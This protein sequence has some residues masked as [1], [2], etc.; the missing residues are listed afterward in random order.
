VLTSRFLARHA[1]RLIALALV[2]C[3]Y[4]LAG[5]PKIT[6]TERQTLASRFRFSRRALPEPTG[7]LKSVREVNPSLQQISGWISAVGAGVALNDLDGDGLSNDMC[8][9]DP[10]V[11]K[12]MVAP[13]P[14]TPQRYKMIVLDPWPLPYDSTTMA[15]MG[16]LPGDVNED[17]RMDLLVYY[18]GRAPVLFLR[19]DH[20]YTPTELVPTQQR[21]YTNAAT[22]ADLDGDGHPDLIIANYFQDGARILDASDAHPQQMQHSMS[23]AF[24]SGRKHIF[25]WT[26]PGKFREVL[27]A[28]PETAALGWTLAVG[29]ADLDGDLL[30]ELYFANDFG[31]DRLLHNR[32]NPGHL[33]FVLVEGKRTFTTPKSKVLG[34]DSFKGMGVDFADVNGD[35]YP[36]MFVSNIAAPYALEESNFL[37]VSTGHPELFRQGIAPYTDRSEQLGLSRN[38]W[39]WDARLA[40]FDNDGVFE[41]VQA[42]G[43]IK[44]QV[45]RW[46]ELHEIAMSNDQLLQ[47]PSFWHSFR[48]GDDLSG[49]R[50]NPFFVRAADGRYYDVGD[51]IGEGQPEN[52]RGIAIA[53]VDGDGR[54]DYITANQWE[55]SWF[56]HNESPKVGSYLELRVLAASG[57]PYIG[58]TATVWLPDGREMVSQVD[59]GS[60]HSGKS[61]PDLH[62]GLGPIPSSTSLRVS[63]RWRDAAGIHEQFEQLH[64]GRFTVVL[65]R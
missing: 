20:G 18:W 5:L 8:W 49:K 46:P 65:R 19:T 29:A 55:T 53:D 42:T 3:L 39:S 31:P 57:S 36:D 4:V 61:S 58:A 2:A 59:G 24:N 13:V 25:L 47:N 28:L 26:A 16:C 43:F 37:F 1:R 34:R 52:S 38:G 35:G 21:W 6:N 23:R 45:N 56:H 27:N 14:G 62:F 60:G 22:F 51:L 63:V 17:G 54:L 7:E 11:D 10:R 30:P 9:V 64:P 33:K 12:V 32:S 50:G 48:L 15:P 41:A 44:G 40:D